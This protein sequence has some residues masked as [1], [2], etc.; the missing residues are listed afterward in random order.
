[1][2]EHPEHVRSLDQRLN[3][4]ENVERENRPENEKQVPET[5]LVAGCQNLQ[6]YKYHHRAKYELSANV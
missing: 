2:S 6:I 4:K 3:A 1:L 5:D